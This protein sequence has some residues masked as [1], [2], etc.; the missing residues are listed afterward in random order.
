MLAEPTELLLWARGPGFEW[1]VLIFIAGVIIRIIEIVVLSRKTDLAPARPIS[2][3]SG[4]KT[5]WSR[6]SSMPALNSQTAITYGAGYLFHIGLLAT[7][8]FAMPHIEIFRHLFG[9]GWPALPTMVI[10]I[11][12]VL[13]LVSMIVLLIDRIHNPVKRMLSTLGDYVAWVVTFL[14]LLTGYLAYHHMLLPYPQMLTLHILSA[15]LLLVLLPFTKL[16]HAFTIFIARWY[17][18]DNFGRKGVAS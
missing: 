4:V 18:G 8:F 10:D 6:F 2:H 7:I 9:F 11:L 17:T 16:A 12:T 3:G 15:E 14:P 5:I 13:A 1:A